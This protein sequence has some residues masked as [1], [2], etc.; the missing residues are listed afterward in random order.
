M[1]YTLITGASSGIGEAL[2]HEF[3]SNG[4]PIVAV[5]RNVVA[6]EE[7]V[8]KH[9]EMHDVDIIA[10]AKDLT[11]EGAVQELYDELKSRGIVVGILVNNAGVGYR[12]PF[13][14]AP[15]DK[16]I[17]MIRL[18]IE[19]LTRL[20]H[21]FLPD[22]VE[23]NEGKILNLGSV[24]GFQPGPLMAVYHGAKAFVVSLSEALVIEL[25]DTNVTVTCLCPGPVD[26]NFFRRAGME[27]ARAH[28]PAVLMEPEKVAHEGYKGLMDGERIV[29]PGFSNKAMTFSRRIMSKAMQARI[30]KE[31]YESKEEE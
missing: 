24:A 4:H 13:A 5:A 12:S 27:D 11:Q 26:T 10:I 2:M 20:T 22:M 9:R 16:L 21:A 30:Q 3:A 18:D 19:A 25:Q 31:F 8:A 17:E 14:E 6:L 28:S 7:V 1:N 15:L 29:M 23:R